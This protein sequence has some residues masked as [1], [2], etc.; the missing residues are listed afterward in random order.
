MMLKLTVVTL[1]GW[2]LPSSVLSYLTPGPL[3]LDGGCHETTR[4]DSLT[5]TTESPGRPC[6][7][8]G[9]V[10][11]GVGRLSVH[12]P[13]NPPPPEQARTLML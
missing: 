1:T 9:K 4:E 7:I 13:M 11:T 6:E 5:A 8:M 10:V 3:G 12:P 2:T